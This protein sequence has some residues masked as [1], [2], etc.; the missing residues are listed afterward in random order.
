MHQKKILVLVDGS[1]RSM[2]TVQY[3]GKFMPP[4]GLHVVLFNV[5]APVPDCYWDLENEPQIIHMVSQLKSWEK[6]KKENIENFME[7]AKS[8]LV[9]S[10][11]EEKFVEIKILNRS[12][13]I[14]RDIVKEAEGGYSAVVLRRRGFSASESIVV[15]SVASKLLSKISFL[16]LIITGQFP[17]VKKILLAID[18]SESSYRV[19]EFVGEYLGG[20]DY[21]VVLFN[22]IRGFGFLAPELPDVLIPADRFEQ[23]KAE[24]E[25]LFV[26]LKE[27]L[28]LAGFN[29]EKVSGKVV[30]GEFSRSGAI[31]KEAT[32][33][34][35]GA[36]VMGRRG[37]SKVQEFFMG[38][39]SHKVIHGGMNHT[40]W[41]V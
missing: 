31:I 17:P 15:G 39:V 13:G 5:F 2:Q 20:L 12:Q 16:P 18:G 27:K 34:G 6:Q 26:Q 35:F 19:V 37:I 30:T 11:F 14:A 29:P 1:E 23:A 9:K 36:I 22:V 24:I 7:N 4:S 25:L 40:V 33:G 21:E 32:K 38:R 28:V 8:L 41:V 3:V 10:G